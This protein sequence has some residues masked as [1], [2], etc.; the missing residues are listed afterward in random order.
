MARDG[1]PESRG[2]RLRHSVWERLL[3]AQ[4]R[5]A[6]SFRF[7]AAVTLLGCG[8][9][10][11]LGVLASAWAGPLDSSLRPKAPSVEIAPIT[12]IAVAPGK[13]ANVEFDF[14]VEAG[15]HINSNQPKNSL[16]QPTVLRLTPP[17]NIVVSRISYSAGHELDFEFL[18]GEKFNVY[19]GDFAITAR[20]TT[21]QS[22][23]S[24]TYRVHGA[25]KYQACDNR[26]CYPPKEVPVA[27]DVKVRKLKITH[28]Q[29]NPGQSPHIHQ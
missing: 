3:I 19:S 7:S 25:L 15:F 21:A 2:S 6:R 13:Y 1:N 16:M 23:T 8:P 27:F 17:T 11:A 4:C 18:P 22:M 20:I 12:P 14:R 29:A 24:G 28:P 5:H 9:L 26:Q 10:L